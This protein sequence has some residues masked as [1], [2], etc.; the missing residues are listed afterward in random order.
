MQYLL[1]TFKQTPKMEQ[2][3]FKAIWLG[4]DAS[5]GETLLGIGNKV[6]RA[7]TIRR[8]PKPDKYDKQMFDIITGQAMTPPPTSQAQL[9]PTMVSIHQ[10]DNQQQQRRRRLP[11]NEQL[12]QQNRK[13]DHNFH[14]EQSQ[15]RKWQRQY[16]HWPA[17][18][19]PQHQQVAIAD[20]QC[21]HRHHQRDR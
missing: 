19:W 15:T 21:R 13:V 17:H 6:V 16:Q 3:F 20:Q 8:M 14:Q 9:Q 18:Q 11:Q 1:P 12:R 2:R 7:R 10:G 5:T 4:R